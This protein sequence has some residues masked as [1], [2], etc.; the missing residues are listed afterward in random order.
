MDKL[1]T[2]TK[3][4]PN[5]IYVVINRL[6]N[7]MYYTS[8]KSDVASIIGCSLST[9]IGKYKHKGMYESGVYLLYVSVNKYISDKEKQYKHNVIPP[10]VKASIQQPITINANNKTNN[11]YNDQVLNNKVDTNNWKSIEDSLLPNEYEQYYQQRTV[12][13]LDQ[14]KERYKYSDKQRALIIIRI[15]K[16]KQGI[17][18]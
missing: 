16:E 7:E 4:E 10:I 1:K 8:F 11:V 13:Q 15:G 6:T 14:S 17:V 3:K 9:V 18:D 2:R 5:T 12:E